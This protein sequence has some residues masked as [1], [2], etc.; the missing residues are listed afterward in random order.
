MAEKSGSSWR[1]IRSNIDLLMLF[2]TIALFFLGISAIY[3]AS[4]NKAFALSSF[5]VRQL[6]WGGASAVIY[7]I[8]LRIGYVRF[9]D[10]A[11]PLFALMMVVALDHLPS[12]SQAGALN[13]LMQGGGF[14]LA[15]LAPWVIAQLHEITGKFEAGWTYQLGAVC[16]VCVLA[17]R[18][19]PSRYAAVMK[20]H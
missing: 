9:L 12:P 19:S 3:S 1:E 5:A 4:A 15:S 11:G 6:M 14:L 7:V 16:I 8:V 10:F 17:A 2:A 18:L 13:A 20:A